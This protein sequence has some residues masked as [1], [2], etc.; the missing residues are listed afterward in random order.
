MAELSCALLGSSPVC[1]FLLSSGF[2]AGNSSTSY[3]KRVNKHINHNYAPTLMLQALVRNIVTR[4]IPM[5][6]PAVGGRPYSSAVQNP[7]S[8][9]CASSSPASLSWKMIAYSVY[10]GYE[11]DWI[12]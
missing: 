5:P 1:G 10:K 12:T 3:T 7:S 9:I 8:T 11:L 2:I 4:S 6:Q